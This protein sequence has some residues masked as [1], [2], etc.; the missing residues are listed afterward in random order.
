MNLV[1]TNTCSSNEDDLVVE[2]D[3]AGKSSAVNSAFF[4]VS[5]SGWP[6]AIVENDKGI[7]E[8]SK[9]FDIIT[10]KSNENW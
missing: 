10:L 2:F 1:R 3:K 5:L 9:S 8:L 7:R 6:L 4:L